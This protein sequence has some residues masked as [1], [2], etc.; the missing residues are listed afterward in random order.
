MAMGSIMEAISRRG[1]LNNAIT[2][3]F[4]GAAFWIM[5]TP[6][7]TPATVAAEKM[8]TELR[9][10]ADGEVTNK[11]YFDVSIGDNPAG[12]IV[13][14]LFGKD[15]PITTKNF[16]QLATGENGFG[17]K[18]SIIHRSIASF[19]AQGGDFEVCGN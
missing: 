2:A 15:L 19:M 1:L 9:N 6:V 14:G 12:R 8:K 4:I 10:P 11:V 5:F 3:G 13:I 17:Y 7:K 18:D 16:E